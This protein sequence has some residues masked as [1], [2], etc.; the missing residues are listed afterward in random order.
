[1]IATSTSVDTLS[2]NQSLQ[3]GETLVSARGVIEVGFFSPENSTRRHLGIWYTNVSPFTVVW[4]ANRNT[5]LESKSGVLKLNEK[6]ILVLLNGSNI[7]I[8]SSNIASKA[9]NNPI[10]HLLDSGN[11]VVK[12][13]QESNNFLWQIFDEIG[14]TMIPGMK[15]GWNIEIGL[16]RCIS[17]WKSANHP[18]KGKYTLKLDRRGYP[19]VVIFKGSEMK[20]RVGP[21]NGQ[22][23]AG[24]PVTSDKSLQM[25]VFNEKEVYYEFDFLDCSDF[26]IFILTPS[27]TGSRIFWTSETSTRQVPSTEE[28]DQFMFPS[29]LISGKCHIGS[30]VVFQG[31]N[32][33]AITVIQMASSTYANL[34]IRDGG[35]GCL[36]WFNTLVDLRNFSQLGQDFYIRV[37]ASELDHAGHGN[38]MEKIV[39]LAVGVTISGLIITC[40]C[41]F[42]AKKPVLVNATENFSTENKL[43]EGG[44]GPVYKVHVIAV[45]FRPLFSGCCSAYL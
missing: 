14:D 25:F 38:S 1:M 36:L 37:P 42:I 13:E 39:G 3:D 19:Q 12:N 27:G 45:I 2:M 35:S 16:E 23:W 33:V 29:L 31:I 30:M 6:G 21:W 32:L 28:E 9:G 22:S 43:G 11:F 15:L 8:W 26:N 10:A 44:F 24:Y 18:A 20:V 40:V 4:V 17:S 41:I 34:D 5:P 7:T